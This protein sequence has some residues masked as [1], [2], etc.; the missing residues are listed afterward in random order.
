LDTLINGVEGSTVN[1]PTT[2]ITCPF[3][4]IAFLCDGNDLHLRPA[5][6]Q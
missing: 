5:N 6:Q 1:C 4:G 2:E 3:C